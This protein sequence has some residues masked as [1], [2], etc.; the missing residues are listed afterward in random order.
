MPSVIRWHI[1]YHMK[2][3]LVLLAGY[4]GTGKSYLM[5]LIRKTY[6][7]FDIVSPDDYKEMMWDRYGFDSMQEKDTCIEKAWK[8]Y[9]DGL[10]SD[11]RKGISILSDYPFS[12]KQKD[13][14]LY[15]SNKYDY[16]I[17][18]IRLI[19]DL[20]V[21][22]ERQ[23][24]RDLDPTRHLGHIVGSYHKGMTLNNREEQPC[25]VPYEEFMNRCKN[26]G[27]G[28]F[29]LGKLLKEIDV[30][31]FKKVDYTELMEELKVVLHNTK[32]EENI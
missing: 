32:G 5:D 7:Q 26:R 4:P 19:A 25:M 8:A 23:R 15:L 14:L 18:T 30:S 16:Q 17:I 29:S 3:S 11:M 27:Y 24:K 1:I 6:P 2:K 22:Y 21:L 28:T 31:D 12:E 20:D 10:E 13:K 9:Y